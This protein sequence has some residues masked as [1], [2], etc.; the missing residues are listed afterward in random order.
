M[1][2]TSRTLR[3]S[4]LPPARPTAGVLVVVGEVD[5]A[6]CGSFQEQLAAF[7]DACEGDVIVDLSDVRL[8]AAAGVR[9]LLETADHLAGTARRLRLVCGA[10]VRRVLRAAQVADVLE[11][12]GHLDAAVGAQVAAVR[13]SAAARALDD[14]AEELHRLRREV[15]D[16]RAKLRTRPLLSK[17]LGVLQERYRLPD[18]DTAHRLLCEASQRHNLKMRVLADALL[19]APRPASAATPWWFPGRA[20]TPAPVPDFL[21]GDRRPALDAAELLGALLRAALSRT[22]TSA[23]YAQRFDPGVD[24]LR[25]ERHEGLPADLVALLT[26]VTGDSTCCGLALRRRSRVTVVDVASSL[27]LP[28]NPVTAAM[29]RAGLRA[30]QSTPVLA[31]S[32]RCLAVVSTCDPRPGRTPTPAQQADLDQLAAQAGRWL[33]WH[34]RTTVLDALEHLHQSARGGG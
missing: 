5:S 16:L 8:I 31:P 3:L 28:A 20:R 14:E 13:R 6:A 17:A 25:L 23:G 32:G 34:Q 11:T 33:Q 29:L 27:V 10:E 19:H 30:V 26:E 12:F 4:P 24:G 15:G 9:V 18:E 21:A 1:V 2:F 22:A 7:V